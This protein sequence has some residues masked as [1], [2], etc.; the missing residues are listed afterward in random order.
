MP[1]DNFEKKIEMCS[2]PVHGENTEAKAIIWKLEKIII[3][4]LRR[5]T[6]NNNKPAKLRSDSDR[7]PDSLSATATRDNARRKSFHTDTSTWSGLSDLVPNHGLHT[8][9]QQWRRTPDA[10]VC[11]KLAQRVK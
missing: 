9:W 7:D 11:V 2:G 8:F 1:V 10:N 4:K 3:T 6:S 5:G